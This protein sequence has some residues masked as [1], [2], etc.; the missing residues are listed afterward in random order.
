MKF[1]NPLARA[2][3]E[4]GSPPLGEKLVVRIHFAGGAGADPPLRLSINFSFGW[5]SRRR[6]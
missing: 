1:R 4:I 3:D 5:L 2:I 6:K